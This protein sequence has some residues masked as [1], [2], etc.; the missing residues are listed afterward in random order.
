MKIGKKYEA[1]SSVQIDVNEGIRKERFL[2]SRHSDSRDRITPRFM[3]FHRLKVMEKMVYPIHVHR[4]YEL[5]LV[6]K[7]PYRC[8]LNETEISL[9]KGQVLLI[10]PNDTH[11]DIF[12][13]GQ[14]HYVVH[15]KLEGAWEGKA[16]IRIFANASGRIPEGDFSEDIGLIE[17]IA[18]E[19]THD[20]WLADRMQDALLNMLFWRVIR[21]LPRR[22]LHRGFL[23]SIERQQ[24]LNEFHEAILDQLGQPLKVADVAAR[25]GVPVRTLHQKV[26]HLTGESPAYWI[27]KKK[28]EAAKAALL[29]DRKSI[30]EIAYELGYSNPFH[31][32]QVFKRMTGVS[33]KRWRNERF[34]SPSA[35]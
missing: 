6:V 28:I 16:P 26:F 29:E 13:T 2:R 15:F 12:T 31:F 22:V 21:G 27:R 18:K 17:G 34:V 24:F 25:V 9:G 33:P 4:D 7:G 30:K 20:K 3:D 5:I 35:S 19:S 8:T 23:S 11:Q 1:Q 10:Q 14:M 32:S